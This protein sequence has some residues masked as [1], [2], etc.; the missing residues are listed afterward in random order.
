MSDSAALSE[1]IAST[2]TIKLAGIPESRFFC[3]PIEE[4]FERITRVA[5][6]AM[7]APV[8]AI[9]LISNERQW[10]KSVSGWQVSELPIENALC[11]ITLTEGAATMINDTLSDERT[12]SKPIVAGGPRFRAYAGYPLVDEHNIIIGTLCIFDTKLRNFSA[13]D[14]DALFDLACLAQR[15]LIGEELRSVH[16]E[17]T[18][19]LGISRREAMIDP[20]T[21]LWNRRGA[22]VML[23]AA[24]E[25]ANQNKTPF[26]VALLDLDN[27]KRVNDTYGHQTGD[28]VLRKSASRF[29]RSVRGSDI[30]CRIGGDEFLLLMSDTDVASAKMTTERLCSSMTATPVLTREAAV[31]MSISVGYTTYEAGE[32]IDADDLLKRADLALLEAKGAGRDRVSKSE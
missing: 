20:L 22:S 3:T 4:R 8:A 16:I 26:A 18:A 32:R 6:R 1:T 9:T 27:F 23:K 5:R 13:A 30:V 19:K 24:L 14:K 21:R 17:L 25:E 2:A 12:A 28:E 31:P 10:F 29:V 7:Q 15:E 11:G